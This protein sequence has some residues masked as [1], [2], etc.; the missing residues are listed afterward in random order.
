[1]QWEFL[2]RQD[3]FDGSDR[4]GYTYAAS[5]WRTA[6]PGGWL[7]MTLNS[8]SSDPQPILTFYPDGEHRWNGV[9]PPEAE[10]LLRPAG[11]VSASA[12]GLLRPAP[13]T[14]ETK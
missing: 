5:M 11:A 14:P 8:R 13:N 12:E 1:M 4:R 3:L 7:V 2:G 6:V 10:Y 9:T